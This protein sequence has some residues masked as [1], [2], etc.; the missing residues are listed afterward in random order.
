MFRTNWSPS[1]RLAR[2]LDVRT[3]VPLV[4]ALVPIVIT[5]GLLAYFD[6]TPKIAILLC[7]LALMLLYP[8]TNT[9]NLRALLRSRAGRW[10][11]AL[12][13]AEWLA[14]VLACALSSHPVLSLWG[15]N[16]RRFGVGEQTGLLLFAL[17]SA[18]WLA[19]DRG[20]VRT[21]LRACVSG[22]AVAAVYGIA[23]YFGWDPLQPVQAYQVGEAPFTIVRPP[24]TL[25]HA[26][27]FAAWLVVVVFFGLALD[28]LEDAWPFKIAARIASTLSAVAI[29]LSGTRAAL[30][31]LLVGGL[32]LWIAGRARIQMR[33]TAFVL[34]AAAGLALFFFSPAG[35]MLRARLHWSLED[36]RG[37]A[38][39]YL[40]R[41]SLRMAQ[42]RPI[43]GFG[44]ET[45]A[46]EFP[47]FESVELA[48]AYPDF[49]HESPHNI[50]LDVLTSQGMIGLLVFLSLCGLGAWAALEEWRFRS[51]LAAP[52]AATLAGLLIS[53]QFAVFVFSTALYFHLSLAVLVTRSAP[54]PPG[55]PV[56]SPR[57]WVFVPLGVASLLLVIFAARLLVPDRALSIAQQLIASGDASG[58][59][60]AYRSVLRW[61][62]PGAGSDL[63][64]S[65]AMQQLSA[66]TPIFATRLLARQQALEAGVRAVRTAEDPQNAWYNLS[67]L[68]AGENDAAGVE[69]ALRN[70]IAWSP[71]WFKPHW[72]LAQLLEITNRHQEA[73]AEARA[74]VE[75]DGG[76]DPEVSETW[77]MLQVSLPASK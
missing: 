53:Q 70:A 29:L 35:A 27:Y 18:G 48:R 47:R 4:A 42:Q 2:L 7:G 57:V 62:L 76:R 68:L 26:D 23:Q 73:L 1:E 69:L 34:A 72:A 19:V 25:G 56:L 43:A 58:A 60:A 22:G 49:Y 52:L 8:G 55:T 46:T 38:R 51:S 45:F 64:Y 10:F 71:S 41:D 40:W 31:G 59:A 66:R 6:I 24:G 39:L 54:D 5:P 50:F 13:A 9:C 11:A 17:L 3:L 20:N 28:R 14:A 36:V 37:G 33:T 61:Q 63:G 77:K 32:V 44:P 65:R 15:G 21:L 16:W 12:L 75:L 74:A 67:T 30:L